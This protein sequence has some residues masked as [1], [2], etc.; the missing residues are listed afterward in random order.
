MNCKPSQE[1]RKSSAR[2]KRL[3]V[4]F[5]IKDIKDAHNETKDSPQRFVYR[6]LQRIMGQKSTILEL[7]DVSPSNTK[8]SYLFFVT[9]TFTKEIFSKD[10]LKGKYH[11]TRKTMIA[12]FHI[13][14][15]QSHWT[16]VL[17]T[18]NVLFGLAVMFYNLSSNGGRKLLSFL[19]GN[20]NNVFV[21]FFAEDLNW[22]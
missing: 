13:M 18:L 6:L 2:W 16:P 20:C 17:Y 11:R 4:F 9:R 14:P 7:F 10:I 12:R 19:S 15:V 8:P 21:L 3:P 5:T 22:L 1:N